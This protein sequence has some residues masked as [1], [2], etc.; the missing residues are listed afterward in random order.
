MST[1]NHGWVSWIA[2][3]SLAVAADDAQFNANVGVKTTSPTQSLR[4]VPQVAM[5]ILDFVGI[6][7][8]SANNRT[9][10]LY[11][12]E[13]NTSGNA[14]LSR[15]IFDSSEHGAAIADNTAT[16]YTNINSPFHLDDGH[17]GRLSY[18]A[19]AAAGAMG[20]CSGYIRFAGRGMF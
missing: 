9:F 1:R 14:L 3:Y 11:I 19:Y 16:L 6:L 12:Y 5:G 13:D 4:L 2:T 18:S 8:D 15:M 20:N 7:I 10:E 17:T